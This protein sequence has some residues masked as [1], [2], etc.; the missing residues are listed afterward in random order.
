MIL[1]LENL[2]EIYDIILIDTP[3]VGLV[4]DGVLI[5]QKVDVPL[6]VVKAHYSRKVFG[7]SID[8]L[9]EVHNFKNLSIVLNSVKH[10]TGYGGY[11]YGYGYGNYY[12][13]Y[14]EDKETKNGLL[15]R[16]LSI[17]K[18]RKK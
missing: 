8:K 3:P 18:R 16:L 5:M 4:T 1:L 6:Y 2:K 14:Y 7:K 10:A 12:G 15:A 17:F 9:V 13:G 11:K